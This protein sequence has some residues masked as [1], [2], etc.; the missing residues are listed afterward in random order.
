MN[1]VSPGKLT[2]LIGA[3]VTFIFSWL[4]WYTIS[5]LGSGFSRNAWQSGTFPMATW[6]PLL[7]V[8]VGFVV[9]ADAFKFVELPEKIWEFTLDQLVLIM[10][11]FAF[12][13]TISYL[14]ID[15]GGASVGF[16][17]ILCFLGTIAMVAGFF[18]DKAGVGVNPNASNGT[19]PFEQPGFPAPGQPQAPYGQATATPPPPA[20]QQ[21]TP[22]P[23]AQP[24]E[25]PGPPPQEPGHGAF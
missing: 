2:I 5:G 16:G 19:I 17:L 18:L 15:K 13:V 14:I 12:L 3:G 9:A 21:P 11:A 20:Q 1:D 7:A 4:P 8:A 10:S 23:Y 25:N 6:A 22:P 24:T